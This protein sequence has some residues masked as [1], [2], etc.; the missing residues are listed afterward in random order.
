MRLKSNLHIYN[1][2]KTCNV[3]YESSNTDQSW[4]VALVTETTLP[5]L[6]IGGRGKLRF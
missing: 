2:K 5:C 6:I 3:T 4:L 1:K